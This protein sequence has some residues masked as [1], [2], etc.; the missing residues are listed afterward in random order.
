MSNVVGKQETARRHLSPQGLAA[1]E[2]RD[3]QSREQHVL[4][5]ED[6]KLGPHAA[7]GDVSGCSRFGKQFG[8]WSKS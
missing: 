8:S 5:G 3:G 1:S 2:G 7:L 4:A 6:V